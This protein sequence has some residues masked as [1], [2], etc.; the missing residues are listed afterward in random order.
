MAAG[1][2]AGGVVE[3]T[4][5]GGEA[6]KPGVAGSGGGSGPR[7]A[8]ALADDAPEAAVADNTAG[9]EGDGADCTALDRE[10]NAGGDD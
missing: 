6:G 4:A 9:A 5:R 10:P 1:S 2:M 3:A 7:P 8:V